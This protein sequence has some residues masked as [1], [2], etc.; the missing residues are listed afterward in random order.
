MKDKIEKKIKLT[1]ESKTKNKNQEN[2]LNFLK[3]ENQDYESKDKIKNKL[4]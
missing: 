1:N 4:K 3:I 2:E